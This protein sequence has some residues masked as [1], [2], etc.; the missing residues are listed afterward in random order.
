MTDILF[1][2]A[3]IALGFYVKGKFFSEDEPSKMAKSELRTGDRV[4]SSFLSS[5]AEALEFLFYY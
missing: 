3:G 2:I 5:E 1:F 4:L